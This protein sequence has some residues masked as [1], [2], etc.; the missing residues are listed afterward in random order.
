MR[1]ILLTLACAAWSP[2]VAVAE[3]CT[4]IRFEPGQ[5]GATVDGLAPA[6]GVRCYSLAVRPGQQAHVGIVAGDEGVA[7][8]V[9]DVADNRR[10]VDFVTAAQRYELYVHQTFR[11]PAAVPFSMLVQVQ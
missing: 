8:S 7:V 6:E 5:S 3:D 2:Q 1:P 10:S 9:S 4:P 11:A